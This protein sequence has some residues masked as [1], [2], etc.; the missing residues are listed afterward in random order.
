MLIS[1]FLQFSVFVCCFC[2]LPRDEKHLHHICL[3]IHVQYVELM[4]E[5]TTSLVALGLIQSPHYAASSD[6]DKQQ[7]NKI[8]CGKT[9][10]SKSQF[11]SMKPNDPSQ[12]RLD[13]VKRLGCGHQS[14]LWLLG[15]R[16]FSCSAVQHSPSQRSFQKDSAR[17][18]IFQLG[19][20]QLSSAAMRSLWLM[21][22]IHPSLCYSLYTALK[23]SAKW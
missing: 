18:V 15:W 20:I 2:S 3:N 17:A 6:N 21:Y 22:T 9:I 19:A 16:M 7:V 12:A 1:T 11:S 8:L 23:Y 4:P 13:K 14:C 10:P 5:G